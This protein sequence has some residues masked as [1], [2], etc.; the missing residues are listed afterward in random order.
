ME[1]PSRTDQ[2]DDEDVIVVLFFDAADEFPFYDCSDS[3]SDESEP[4]MSSSDPEPSPESSSSKA[5]LRRRRPAS[6]R[7]SDKESNGT[8]FDSSTISELGAFVD[9]KLNFGAKRYELYPN[10]KQNGE[11][12]ELTQRVASDHE[13]EEHST[14]TTV[15]EVPGRD[16]IDSASELDDSSFS[17]LVFV[18]G[19]VIKAI[20]FQINLFITF[21]TF[22]IWGFY[23]LFMFVT[24]PFRTIRRLREYFIGKVVR[25]I[26]LVCGLISPLVHD[27]FKDHK[28]FLKVA[29]RYGWG[30]LWAFYVCFVLCSLLALSLVISGF[31]M[32]YLV[33]EPIQMKEVLNFDFAK[34][35]PVAYV[36]IISCADAGCG[37]DCEDRM[38]AQKLMGF[39]VI[40]SSHKLQVTVSLTV[41]ESEY[42]RN[43]GIFQVYL[44]LIGS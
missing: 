27:W 34:L 40:P 19:L 2:D 41:P 11:E 32:S 23:N 42:N 13:D 20:G 44:R 8:S 10:S 33:D 5:N 15:N 31:L 25:F 28:A 21:V 29:L 1:L 14:V 39:R 3:F 36:P 30:L 22:P 38:E 6:R 17:L 26:E 43:L 35:R 37:I 12:S 24:D 4:S 9:G 16:S 7:V 18:A